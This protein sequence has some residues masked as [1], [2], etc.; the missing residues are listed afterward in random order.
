M[1]RL[2]CVATGGIVPHQAMSAFKRLSREGR[3]RPGGMGG[4]R[5][6]W[7]IAYFPG[8]R[9]R[10]VRELGDAYSSVRY[11]E[12]AHM[13]GSNPEVRL[14]I[15]NLWGAPSKELALGPSGRERVAP[16]PGTDREGNQWIF[17]FDGRVG[18]SREGGEAFAPSPVKETEGQ[19]VFREILGGLPPRRDAPEAVAELL[20]GAVRRIARDY[21]VEAINFALSDGRW[22]FLGRF[23]EKEEPWNE[24]HLCRTPKAVVG[25][26]E[27]LAVEGWRWDPL[28]RRELAAFNEGL[29]VN[30]HEL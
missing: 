20:R 5:T 11:D 26:S 12:T 4:Y 15:G 1:C 28:G 13:T 10:L 18:P 25:C 21:S 16:F 22:I 24:L 14:L 17:A 27:P 29:E 9:L 7:G 6:G 30:F 2:L 19:R 8:G 23:V 3:E